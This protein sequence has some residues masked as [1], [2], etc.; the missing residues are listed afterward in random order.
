M[1]FKQGK[2]PA[3]M[4]RKI[5]KILETELPAN[6]EKGLYSMYTI[7]GGK[8]DYYTPVDTTNLVQSRT[9]RISNTGDGWRM[10]YGYYTDYAAALHNGANW[11]PKP[12]GTPGKTNGG[13]NPNA[14]PGWMTIAW[15]EQGENAIKAFGRMIEP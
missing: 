1:P 13:Y 3:D 15:N 9:Y 4:S 14:K 2:S 12:P 7:L 5:K 8:A 11:Q 6:I 10:T